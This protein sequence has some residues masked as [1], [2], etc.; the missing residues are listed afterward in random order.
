MWFENARPERELADADADADEL[1]VT[2]RLLDGDVTAFGAELSGL[3]E[4]MLTRTLD[5]RVLQDG[6]FYLACVLAGRGRCV[7][8]GEEPNAR[9]IRAGDRWVRWHEAGGSAG[10]VARQ[11]A[12][13][14]AESATSLTDRHAAGRKADP[15]SAAYPALAARCPTP[16]R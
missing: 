14:S 8:A 10:Y 15:P 9:L 6:R 16:E 2:R 5:E 1:R 3:H 12:H 11:H 4:E 13:L 7:A